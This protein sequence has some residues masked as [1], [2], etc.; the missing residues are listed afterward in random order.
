MLF[1]KR[2]Q[3]TRNSIINEQ[4]IL[5]VNVMDIVDILVSLHVQMIHNVFGKT[6]NV[7]IESLANQALICPSAPVPSE[8]P[9][10][11]IINNLLPSSH[12]SFFF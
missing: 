7:T 12:L 11:E 1:L 10:L 6:P 2:L 9:F 4:K 3:N 5:V 8:F